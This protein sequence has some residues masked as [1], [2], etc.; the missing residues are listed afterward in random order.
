MKLLWKF[1]LIFALVFGLGMSIVGWICYSFLD[2][3]R[4]G[5]GHRGGRSHHAGR[6]GC[7]RVYG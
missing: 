3:Q 4:Q 2:A 7:T 5:G 6:F 1:S